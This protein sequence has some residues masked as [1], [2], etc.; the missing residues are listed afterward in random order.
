[1]TTS[2]RHLQII[3]VVTLATKMHVSPIVINLFFVLWPL[4]LF[5]MGD[6]ILNDAADLNNDGHITRSEAHAYEK[7]H[8]DLNSVKKTSECDI[9]FRVACC[10]Y[11]HGASALA[12]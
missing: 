11:L 4:P 12:L 10:S 6:Q 8:D 9:C 3:H 2:S 7:S 1:M 5:V